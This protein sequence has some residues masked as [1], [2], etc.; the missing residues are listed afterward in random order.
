MTNKI[1]MF[2]FTHRAFLFRLL[3][4]LCA[5]GTRARTMISCLPP[6]VSLLLLLLPT[7]LFALEN[8]FTTPAL[9]WSSWYAAPWGSQVTEEFVKASAHALISSGLAR[10]GYRFVNVDEGWLKGRHPE[11][12]TIYEDLQKFPSGMKGLGDYITSLPAFN[13][14]GERMRYGLYSSRGTCQCGTGKYHAVGSH[15][16]EAADAEW[17]VSAG[18]SWLK[19]DSC[20][21]SQDHAT[22][23]GDYGRWRDAMN[24]SGTKHGNKPIWF[25]LCGWHDWYSPPDP[26]LKYAGGASL[27]NSWRIFGDGGSFGAITGA[28]NTMARLANYSGPGS[29]E[30]GGLS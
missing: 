11:N 2:Q 6:L 20:C 8:G 24:A 19:I 7:A 17:M 5:A 3:L 10:K 25:N 26:T 28:L 15:G 4:D 18:A 13:G 12:N 22:A 30:L 9:G 29:C 14:T 21:G 16:H 23:F 1:Q 27:G